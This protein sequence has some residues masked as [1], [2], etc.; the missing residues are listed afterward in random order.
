MNDAINV[1]VYYNTKLYNVFC[2][3]LLSSEM[4]YISYVFI[5]VMIIIV[6]TYY[7]EGNA[8]RYINCVSN[9]SLCLLLIFFFLYK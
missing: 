3:L 1:L 7:F 9:A 2:V 4:K 8:L 5:L 6:G